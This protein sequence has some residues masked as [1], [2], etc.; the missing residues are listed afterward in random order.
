V[1]DWRLAAA[2]PGAVVLRRPISREMGHVVLSDGAGG[3]IEAHDTASGVI[4]GR[5]ADRRWD[6]G[7]LVPGIRYVRSGDVPDLGSPPQGILRLT[8]PL[9]SSPR[10]A[11]LQRRLA[12]LGFAPGSIDGVYGPQTAHAVRQYQVS[13][14]LVADGEAGSRTLA[15]LGL[16]AP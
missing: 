5:L 16:Q 9:T 13:A 10:V 1:I 8:V 7:I 11:A 3:T 15:R 2:I 4:E 14:G 6:M 12:E